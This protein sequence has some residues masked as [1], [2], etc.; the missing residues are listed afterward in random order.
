MTSRSYFG[1][2]NSTLGSVVPL[3]MFFLQNLQFILL[4][5][6]SCKFCK[7]L[8]RKAS[9][10]KV[11]ESVRLPSIVELCMHF[12]QM[13]KIRAFFMLVCHHTPKSL[14]RCFLDSS[15]LYSFPKY[16][17]LIGFL[18]DIANCLARQFFANDGNLVFFCFV[19]RVMEL[20]IVKVV[21]I[22]SW[23]SGWGVRVFK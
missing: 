23:S 2:M 1:K 9:L 3:A 21:R 12:L 16:T 11:P 15:P 19:A 5:T 4:N 10:D 13:K 8:F 7:L 6:I 22:V 20:V 18:A 17:V 14:L